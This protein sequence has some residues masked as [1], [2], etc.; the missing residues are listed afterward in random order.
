VAEEIAFQEVFLERGAIHGDEGVFRPRAPVV[1]QACQEAL[2]GAALAADQD[3]GVGV[4]R[5]ARG[6]QDFAHAPVA[7]QNPALGKDAPQGG[8][9]RLHPVKALQPFQHQVEL[10]GDEGLGKIVEGPHFDRGDRRLDGGVGRDHHHLGFRPAGDDRLEHLQPVP[11]GELHVQEHQVGVL[12]VKPFEAFRARRRPGGLEALVFE[13]HLQ[14]G[15][16][17]AVVIDD[18]GLVHGAPLPESG[19][20]K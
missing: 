15:Q 11:V 3:N 20:R 6:L 4:G 13:V 16:D 18:Q 14:G 7:G 8:D 12:T 10:A 5:L 2:P 9:L 17:V 1:D 19:S